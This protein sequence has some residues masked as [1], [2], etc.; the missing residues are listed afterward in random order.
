MEAIPWLVHPCRVTSL[1]LDG[2]RKRNMNFAGEAGVLRW[3]GLLL[4]F[5]VSPLPS[6]LLA[7][8]P[9]VAKP[10]PGLLPDWEEGPAVAEPVSHAEPF[11][12][13][14]VQFLPPVLHPAPGCQAPAQSLGEQQ[15]PEVDCEASEWGKG[16]RR[17]WD[18]REGQQIS[19]PSL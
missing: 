11:W 3:V 10:L 18:E 15:P 14:R 5:L 7:F 9:S 1:C 8:L 6:P 16:R 12:Q 19:S 4:F 17:C 2:G 13:E